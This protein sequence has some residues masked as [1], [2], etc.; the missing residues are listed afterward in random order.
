[1]K[2][3]IGILC[4]GDEELAPFLPHIEN[5]KIQ[6][7]ALLKFYTGTINEVE[8]VALYSGVCKVNA[9]IAAQ[10]LINTFQVNIIINAGTAGGID[11]NIKLFDTIISSECAYHDMNDDILTEFHPWLPSIYFKSD[12]F[13]LSIAEKMATKSIYTIKFGRSVTGE[14]FITD[15]G[16]EDIINKYA[17][18][19]VDMETTAVAQVCY[20]NH[21][22]FIAIRT[23]TDT[24]DHSGV[25]N[26][27]LNCKKASEISK[28][29][30]LTFM[31]ALKTEKTFYK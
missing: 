15:E 2:R 28:E 6:E 26:F 30:T 1:M 14:K 21:I 16:R 22:P 12:S 27:E 4:A 18:L 5:Y 29:V 3:K 10:I 9:A 24:A 31:E 11:K 7:K 23:I 25:K 17:P 19:S 8:I 13:L 20:A